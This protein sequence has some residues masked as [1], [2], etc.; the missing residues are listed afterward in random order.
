M[1]EIEKDIP[2]PVGSGRGREQKYPLAQ[3]NPGES[4][5]V[6]ANGDHRERVV[7]RIGNSVASHRKKNAHKKFTC[8]SVEG[9]VRC[10]RLE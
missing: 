10:W 5:Y 2:T 4:F 1:Y 7:S 6:P 3:L 9:G 8:R